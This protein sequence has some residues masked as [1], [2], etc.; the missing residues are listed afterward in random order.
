MARNNSGKRV[1]DTELATES[2]IDSCIL[3]ENT[4]G[5]RISNV[6]NSATENLKSNKPIDPSFE[7]KNY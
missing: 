6:N 4:R 3:I 5:K 1:N 2:I 7:R